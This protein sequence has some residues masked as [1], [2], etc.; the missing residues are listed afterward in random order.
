MDSKTA[1]LIYSRLLSIYPHTETHFLTFSNPYE[2]LVMTILSAQT[3]DLTVNRVAPLL[4][5]RYPSPEALAGAE[6]E[7]VE[8]LIRPTGFYHTKARH[9]IGSALVIVERFSGLVP[10]RMEE[11]LSLPGVGRKTA[12]IVLH[13]SFRV[14]AGVAVDTHVRRL[15]QRIGLSLSRDPNQI[16]QDLIRLYPQALWGEITYVL[17]RHGREVCDARRPACDIC[18]IRDL[19]D[20]GTSEAREKKI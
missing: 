9:I 2:C 12:N 7:D 1:L 3:T 4:F 5:E 20:Y 10:N 17:I 13:H 15:S 11:L 8:E 16:E 6:P 14:N 19:C 18:I